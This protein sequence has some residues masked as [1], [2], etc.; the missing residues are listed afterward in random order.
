MPNQEFR[1]GGPAS[2]LN[3]G[4]PILD[5]VF[6]GGAFRP[7]F[8]S[9]YEFTTVRVPHSCEA[10]V[11]FSFAALKS[12]LAQPQKKKAGRLDPAFTIQELVAGVGFEPTT[13]G[14]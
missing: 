1:A 5:G 11:C 13:F 3:L 12:T 8:L 7:F 10:R 14:L 4:C 9:L 2:A 6:K